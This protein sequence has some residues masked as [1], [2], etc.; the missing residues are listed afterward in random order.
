M[1]YQC[2]SYLNS[3]VNIYAVGSSGYIALAVSRL[4]S[5]AIL[6]IYNWRSSRLMKSEAYL[7]GNTVRGLVLPLY[8]EYL[9]YLL[10]IMFV[11]GI[12]DLANFRRGEHNIVELITI[13][14]QMTLEQCL[15]TS[16]AIF[17]T[18]YG[19]GIASI[20]EALRIG[21]CWGIF[22]GFLF[23]LIIGTTMDYAN[24]FRI[25]SSVV[26]SNIAFSIFMVYI[27][28]L[29]IFYGILSFAPIDYIYRRPACFFYAKFNLLYNAY[30]ALVCI[31]LKCGLQQVYFSCS[32]GLILLLFSAILQPFVIFRTLQLD[33]QVSFIL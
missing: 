15:Y 30:V 11:F 10:G 12:M 28:L 24:V 2:G 4:C 23:F 1:V 29:M 3:A 26:R 25:P 13:P 6:C 14:F 5:F 33:S 19:A 18:K 16:L 32:A 22:T 31:I 17:L 7:N 21:I 9:L 20:H 27:S 8:S